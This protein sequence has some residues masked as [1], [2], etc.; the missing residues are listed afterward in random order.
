MSA[1]RRQYGTPFRCPKCPPKHFY[2]AL[3][4]PNIKNITHCPNCGTK[5][6]RSRPK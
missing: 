1:E 3:H 5:L 4:I 2:G 6:V